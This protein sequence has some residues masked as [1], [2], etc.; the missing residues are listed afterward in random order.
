MI[1]C[2]VLYVAAG[3]RRDEELHP[4]LPAPAVS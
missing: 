3:L 2:V 1:V 4:L